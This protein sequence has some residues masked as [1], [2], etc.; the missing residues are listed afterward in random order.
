MSNAWSRR[1]V[2]G[3][4]LAVAT[5]PAFALPLEKVM[6]K[7]VLRIAVY[8]DFAPWSWTKD[9][10]LTGIDVDLGKLLADRLGLAVDYFD[11]MAGEG[12]DD[13]LR[14]AVWKGPIMG[15]A[16]ADIMMH[17]P[18]DRAFALRNDRVFIVS[19]YYRESFAMAC[20]R[21]AVDCE[22]APA[23]FKGHKIAAEIDSVPD[24]YFTGSFGGSL[25][26]DVAHMPS[27]AAAV[28][29]VKTGKAEVVMATRAQVE[30][31]IHAGGDGL[32]VRRSAIPM[33]TSQGWD[34]GM[35]VKDDARDL[36]DRIE[37]EMA[38]MLANGTLDSLFARYGVTRTPPR[39]G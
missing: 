13:D 29:A 19:P 8:Q 34:I 32:A 2:I 1:S 9:G 7:K 37:T 38:A 4:A 12:V 30:S 18:Y 26:S 5:T 36:G 15:A 3:G 6:A 23:E 39:A 11:L 10:K 16:A 22:A 27:G 17:V 24:F 33:L 31:A 28:N 35:A 20:D 25:R 21:T 14:I